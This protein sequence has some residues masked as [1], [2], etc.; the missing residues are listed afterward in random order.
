MPLPTIPLV[1]VP[2]DPA[3]EETTSGS[4]GKDGCS[5]EARAGRTWSTSTRRAEILGLRWCDVDLT[6]NQ[7]AEVQTRLKA[8]HD[9][10]RWTQD[11]AEPVD[12]RHRPGHRGRAAPTPA[13]QARERLSLAPAAQDHDLVFC[14]A[15]GR[16]LEPAG[17][18][19]RFHRHA[20]EAHLPVLRFRDLRHTHATLGLMPE[21]H[22][23]VMQ[24]RLSHSSVAFTLDIYSHALP[25][26]QG[27]AVQKLVVLNV[28]HGMRRLAWSRASGVTAVAPEAP[29]KPHRS[30]PLLL[31]PRLS[32]PRSARPAAR[33]RS[34][35]TRG[36]RAGA[37]NGF[38][39]IIRSCADCCSHLARSRRQ[40]ACGRPR[41]WT[42]WPANT[43]SPCPTGGCGR[44][45]GSL[46]RANIDHLAV[47]ASG[48]WVIDAKT[49]QGALEVRRSGGLF[50]P[51]FDALYI[52][53]RDRTSLVE[54]LLKK[55]A[56][57]RVELQKVQ[58][59]VSVRG[60]LCFVGTEL[61]WFGSSSIVGVPLVGRRGLAKLIK[62]PGDLAA[63]DRDAL[64]GFL[65]QRFPI[66]H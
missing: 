2:A 6:A 18:T 65:S 34:G 27:E 19:Q 10:L 11:S 4:C 29:G 48:V 16:P 45:D 24:K 7:V 8:R 52:A 1:E 20:R 61:P 44:P 23:K 25:T 64:A 58:A 40:R 54:G 57:V 32:C 55:A 43:W 33:R 21:V 14:F 36:V 5:S 30:L 63:A 62:A 46:S 26:M 37:R 17:V 42:S 39:R 3:G 66:A 28:P 51:R 38:G 53:G 41:S 15:D 35:S 47:A 50:S 49:H 56:A 60:A 12:D 31:R 13:A 22:P 9:L 59:D